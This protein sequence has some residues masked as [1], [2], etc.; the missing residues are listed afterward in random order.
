MNGNWNCSS[1]CFDL[2]YKK[3][4]SLMPIRWC[5]NEP[6]FAVLDFQ[7][8]CLISPAQFPQSFVV[9]E[10]EKERETVGETFVCKTCRG[11][12]IHPFQKNNITFKWNGLEPPNPIFEPRSLSRTFPF[13]IFHS[14]GPHLIGDYPP[15]IRSGRCKNYP[16]HISFA[17]VR[18]L[19]WFFLQK[20]IGLK[21][22]FVMK[23][24]CE[25]I[26]WFIL[27]RSFWVM[28]N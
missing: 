26:N 5:W 14:P 21:T 24:K 3:W 19:S 11:R 28:I 15:S 22:F 25:N 18:K 6:L 20:T 1:S 4:T 8:L 16:D 13:W 12:S 9:L 23:E 7:S 17:Q 27:K 2:L 10:W